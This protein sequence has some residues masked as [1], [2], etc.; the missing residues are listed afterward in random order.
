VLRCASLHSNTI[1]T[2]IMLL[3]HRE[4][5]R[6]T[7]YSKAH[8]QREMNELSQRDNT[9]A[10]GANE[11]NADASRVACHQANKFDAPS[12]TKND[13]QEL[14]DVCQPT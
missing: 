10:V 11:K 5:Q 14:H 4:S 1:A 7:S 12:T 3:L 2:Q 13:D 9:G 8:R 6:L